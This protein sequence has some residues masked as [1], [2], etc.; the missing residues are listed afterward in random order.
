MEVKTL[1]RYERKPGKFSLHTLMAVVAV[2]GCLCLVMNVAWQSTHGH[3]HH[4]SRHDSRIYA[5]L[6]GMAIQM[7]S[8]SE[9]GNRL[10]FVNEYDEN[11]APMHSWRVLLLPEM[12]MGELLD[13]YS[14]Q[15]PWDSLHN[16]RL[17]E[18]APNIYESHFWQDDEANRK[19]LTPYRAI[20]SGNNNTRERLGDWGKN[21]SKQNRPIIV[22]DYSNPVLWMQ[23]DGITLE[24]IVSR[25]SLHD[26]RMEGTLFIFADGS[27]RVL[28][29]EDLIRLEGIAAEATGKE[30]FGR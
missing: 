9:P 1:R 2:V 28:T 4:R 5:S 24:E 29:R 19:G 10:P 21:I 16:R 22:L 15:Q 18:N 8:L 6:I 12:E 14:L 27:E 17:L 3:Y 20:V 13:Q 25:V 30:A 7:K 11:G 23:P 26:A